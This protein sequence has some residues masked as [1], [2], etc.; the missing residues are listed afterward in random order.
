MNERCDLSYSGD[1]DLNRYINYSHITVVDVRVGVSIDSHS[2]ALGR[3]LLLIVVS[4]TC[5][6]PN[7]KITKFNFGVP[8]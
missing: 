2:Q 3:Q 8:I 4:E 1:I 6:R 7:Q 5:K